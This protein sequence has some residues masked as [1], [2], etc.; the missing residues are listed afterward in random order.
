MKKSLSCHQPVLFSPG[1]K[2]AKTQGKTIGKWS[3]MARPLSSQYERF[4]KASIKA[5]GPGTSQ[6]PIFFRRFS[7]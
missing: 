7:W 5:Y 2:W 6:I 1:K 4:L 3:N